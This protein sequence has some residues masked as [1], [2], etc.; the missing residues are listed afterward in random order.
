M[1][2][3]APATEAPATDAPATDSP[4]TEAPATEAPA[5][6]SNV[7]VTYTIANLDYSKV[8]ATLKDKII[9]AVKEGVLSSLTG[10]AKS[11]IMVELS[12][13]S[14]I[15]HVTIDPKGDT[16]ADA[17]KS[18]ITASQAAMET[19]VTTKVTEVDGV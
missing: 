4:A 13:G 17:L 9:D 11:E 18:T 15:A 2:T 19:S 5:S 14:I 6:T 8:D 16:T 10:Y 7:R 1:G 12:A 3:E